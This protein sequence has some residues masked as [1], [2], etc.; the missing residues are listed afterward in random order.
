MAPPDDPLPVT[1]P[2]AAWWAPPDQLDARGKKILALL[3]L[4]S[5]PVGYLNTLLTQT[6]A[7]AADEFHATDAAQGYSLAAV[8]AGV[9]ISLVVVSLADR[10]GRR[11]IA[12]ASAAS[13]PIA[14]ATGALAP[15]LMILTATQIVG[16]PLAI[17]LG[18]VIAIIAA[19]EMPKGSRAYAI[20]LVSI[21]TAVGAGS[22]LMVLPIADLGLRG[23]R[24]VYVAPLL[25]L[26]IVPIMVKHL[27]ESRRY[28][29]PHARATVRGHGNRLALLAISGLLVNLL[30]APASGFQNRYLKKARGFSARR[31]SLFSLTTNTPGGLGVVF[32]GRFADIHGRRRIAAIGLIGGTLATVGVF[33]LSGAWMWIVGTMGAVVGAMAV[34]A[35]GVYSAELFPTGLRGQAN[36]VIT[37]L[38]LSGS[39]IGLL[40]AGAH[41]HD[42][43]GYAPI[44]T[45]L[46]IGPLVVAVLIL[47]AYPE[48]ARRELEDLNPE[49][50][51]GGEPAPTP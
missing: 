25:F 17:S 15:N 18:L 39:A 48:T 12:I 9:L 31:V 3:V 37:V 49:D 10:R 5:L 30:V 32:G 22:C 6:I 7:F 40:L 11:I 4:A 21:A 33:A 51:L 23:W 16:R 13:A 26:A 1:N 42:R 34:P 20:S 19:E 8:R 14:C 36:A 29:A 35:L 50:R 2:R 38:S 43:T 46:S 41:I 27:P 24:L 44:M 47:L 28:D 45:V